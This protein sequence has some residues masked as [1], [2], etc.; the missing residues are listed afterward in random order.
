MRRTSTGRHSPIQPRALLS[1]PA[2]GGGDPGVTTWVITRESTTYTV[3]AGVT[4][5]SVDAVG[6]GGQGSYRGR[7]GGGARALSSLSVT[8]AESL[9][10]NINTGGGDG[11]LTGFV[12]GKGGGYAG[13][14]RS[15]TPLAIAGGGGGGATS[16]SGASEVTRY[17]WGGAGGESG[18]DGVQSDAAPASNPGLG[19]TTGAGGAGG[20]GGAGADGSAGAALTGGAA[21]DQSEGGGGGGAGLYGGGGGESG[22]D[23]AGGGGGSSLGDTITGGSYRDPAA[24]PYGA[25]YGGNPTGATGTPTTQ[26]NNVQAASGVV[27]IEWGASGVSAPPAALILSGVRHIYIPRWQLGTDHPDALALQAGSSAGLSAGD[28]IPRLIDWTGGLHLAQGTLAQQPTL[29]TAGTLDGDAWAYF[30]GTAWLT[31]VARAGWP[32]SMVV[33][34]VLDW[35]GGSGTQYWLEAGNASADVSG[36]LIGFVRGS[37]GTLVRNRRTSANVD[38]QGNVDLDL[39]SA[40]TVVATLNAAAAS[41]DMTINGASEI[42]GTTG[43]TLD[44]YVSVDG[45][46]APLTLG[47]RATTASPWTGYLR[48]LAILDGSASP[49]TIAAVTALLE[50]DD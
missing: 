37:V 31:S 45:S 12:G 34:A 3:P 11:G 19:A 48:G 18:Q 7:G 50:G 24:N 22:T 33:I 2:A 30:D 8:P 5:I 1:S 32:T 20:T 46:T 27:R 41:Q 26:P 47:A 25:G 29:E 42:S 40:L 49:E 39:S 44:D 6:Q 43:T 10:V 17:G 38:A 36:W 16:D 9:T 14:L 28:P 4:S 15:A 35:R 23:G 13:V 21:G